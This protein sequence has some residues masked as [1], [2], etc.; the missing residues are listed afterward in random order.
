MALC[1]AQE[2]ASDLKTSM[3]RAGEG[4]KELKMMMSIEEGRPV[5]PTRG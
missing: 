3:D 4:V 2:S 5:G 1:P